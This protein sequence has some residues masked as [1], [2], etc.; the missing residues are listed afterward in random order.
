M[1]GNLAA[2][3]GVSLVLNRGRSLAKEV[4]SSI[5]PLRAR[6]DFPALERSPPEWQSNG[7]DFLTDYIPEDYK[8][9]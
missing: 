4:N 3:F 8:N 1:P 2:S 9:T 7:K 5:G 6:I